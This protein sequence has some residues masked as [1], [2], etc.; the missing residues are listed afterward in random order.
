MSE[1]Y[2]A[3]LDKITAQLEAWLEVKAPGGVYRCMFCGSEQWRLAAV[4]RVETVD[5]RV[6]PIPAG[7]T[8][9]DVE[10]LH[11]YMVV[12]FDVSQLRIMP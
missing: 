9:M 10:C 12:T 11:C 2:Y 6:A 3:N 4:R 8:A 1:P 7:Y 5:Y